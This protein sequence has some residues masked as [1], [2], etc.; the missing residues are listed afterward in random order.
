M[1][2]FEKISAYHSLIGDDDDDAS[3][4]NDILAGGES[5]LDAADQISY[6]DDVDASDFQNEDESSA[7]RE[8]APVPPPIEQS[9]D[10]S[11]TSAGRASSSSSAAGG[12]TELMRYKAAYVKD[13]LSITDS[14]A[15]NL[16]RVRH[17]P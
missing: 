8:C 17:L 16:L 15:E 14:E 10:T 4:A 7:C 12:M 2:D 6:G 1:T 5:I 11:I 13:T 9:G 3:D